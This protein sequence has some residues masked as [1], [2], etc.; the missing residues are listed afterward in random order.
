MSLTLVRRCPC[1]CRLVSCTWLRYR[2]YSSSWP[3]LSLCVKPRDTFLATTPRSSDGRFVPCCPFVF[4]VVRRCCCHFCDDRDGGDDDDDDEYD[5]GRFAAAV[6][7]VV[8]TVVQLLL[9][10]ALGE[11]AKASS[12]DVSSQWHR[13]HHYRNCAALV[14]TVQD[15]RI[16][17]HGRCTANFLRRFGSLFMYYREPQA[18]VRTVPSSGPSTRSTAAVHVASVSEGAEA[19]KLSPVAV[20]PSNLSATATMGSPRNQASATA[21]PATTAKAAATSSAATT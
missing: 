14:I 4:M 11:Q 16:F 9:L 3:A 17:W 20:T 12:T 13:L 10:L 19:A 21:A 8:S 5:V 18:V 6:W 2:A 1:V 7:R 15:N